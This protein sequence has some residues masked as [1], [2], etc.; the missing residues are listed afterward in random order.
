MGRVRE[1]SSSSI[2]SVENTVCFSFLLRHNWEQLLIRASVSNLELGS[3]IAQK[4]FSPPSKWKSRSYIGISLMRMGVIKPF[5]SKLDMIA[6]DFHLDCFQCFLQSFMFIMVSNP[7][8]AK[9]GQ[10]CCWV[11]TGGSSTYQRKPQFLLTWYG[12]FTAC[13]EQSYLV[14]HLCWRAPTRCTPF[15]PFQSHP[16]K[17]GIYISVSWRFA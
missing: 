16:W 17:I 2:I 12:A 15:I 13:V 14:L 3:Q 5:L 6:F 9:Q 8:L 10:T 7:R 4:T 1:W 11:E